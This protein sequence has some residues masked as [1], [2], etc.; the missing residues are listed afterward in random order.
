MA[1]KWSFYQKIRDEIK[2]VDYAASIGLTVLRKGKYFSLKEHDSVIIDPNKN[3]Y[4][5]NSTPGKGNS[6][7]KG[8]SI[9]DFAMEFGKMSMYDAISDL[10]GKIT[11]RKKTEIKQQKKVDDK[12]AKAK[13]KLPKPDKNMHKVYAY[14]TKTRHIAW[15][16]VQDFTDRKMLYQDEYGNCVFVAYDV[17]DQRKPVFATRRGTNT[18]KPFYGDVKGCDYTKCFYVDNHS[19]ILCITESVIDAMSIITMTLHNGKKM[20]YLILTGVGKWKSI[21]H[22]LK[23]NIK[24]VYIALDNDQSGINTAISICSYIKQKYPNIKREWKLPPKSKGKDWNKVLQE[25]VYNDTI[26]WK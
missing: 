16:V 7:G 24:K 10:S 17:D 26:C 4:W 18:Y 19:D 6:I 9:I 8:G 3:C 11:W 12:K 2:I 20:N 22:Y 1:D 23:R 25:G 14:L 21:A 13:I 5:R 15:T